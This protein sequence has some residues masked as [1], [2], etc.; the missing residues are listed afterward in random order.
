MDRRSSEYYDLIEERLYSAVVADVLY[1]LGAW[2]QV[3]SHTIRPL[4]EDARIV[5]RAATMLVSE[6]Y[7]VPAEPYKLEME[8]LDS[9]QPGEVVCCT[10]QGST[11]AAVWGELLSTATRAR[12]GRGALMDCL[13]RDS[14]GIVEMRFPVFASGLSPADSKGR[15]DVVATQVPIHV[16]GVLIHPGDLVVC[17]RDGCVAV[18][19]E[20]EERAIEAALEKVSGENMVRELLAGGASLQQVFRD[21]GIL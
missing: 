16:G 10:A 3:L 19:Q 11:R 21:H 2:S 15:L 20:L 7:E 18:P 13:T 6:V 1:S 14:W 5:G 4:Y 8:L 9:I 12:G 17:D